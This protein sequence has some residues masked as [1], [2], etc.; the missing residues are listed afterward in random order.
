M[1]HDAV[2]VPCSGVL[3]A[4]V[5]LVVRS[6]RAGKRVLLVH[7]GAAEGAHLELG[8]HDVLDLESPSVVLVHRSGGY[9]EF[10]SALHELSSVDGELEVVLAHAGGHE[11]AAAA[12]VR[13]LDMLQQEP[14]GWSLRCVFDSEQALDGAID[15]VLRHNALEVDGVR[16]P[17]EGTAARALGLELLLEKTD[18]AEP[19]ER[20]I[21]HPAVTDLDVTLLDRLAVRH[22]ERLAR[23]DR[24]RTLEEELASSQRKAD[25][26]RAA[27]EALSAQNV[28]L[29]EADGD[30]VFL[31]RAAATEA[32]LPVVLED[33]NFRI[34]H[35]SDEPRAA[36]PSLAELLAPTRLRRVAEELQPGTPS[37]VRLG[38]PAAG[39]RLVLRLGRRRPCGYLSVLRC[40]QRWPPRLGHLLSQLEAP[41]VTAL[42]YEHGLLRI[43]QTIRSQLLRG[44]FQGTLT[45]A[46]A[47]QAGRL[48]GW[49]G[50]Q[51]RRLAFVLCGRPDE[52]GER[53]ATE[54]DALRRDAERSGIVAGVVGWGLA[55]LLPDEADAIGR[56]EDWNARSRNLAIGLSGVALSPQDAPRAL[57][58]AEWAARIACETNRHLLRFEE[59]GVDRLL[60]PAKDAGEPDL[61][62]PL[63]LLRQSSQEL[64]FDAVETVEAY[65]ESSGNVRSAARALHVHVNT[66]R[67]RLERIA[68]LSGLD[69]DDAG[70]RFEV[71]LALRLAAS[72]KVLTTLVD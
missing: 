48:M 50:H 23:Q 36:P 54:I 39:A 17:M 18:L 45:G 21:R 38:I 24:M 40:P 46:E 44:V 27:V 16:V 67:Y 51:R 58:Q 71:Q 62:R 5:D 22:R 34:R 47:L 66:L 37:L 10:R 43:E 33:E 70:S 11:V 56:L 6:C 20:L 8:L 65:L 2:V 4:V 13:L 15:A 28:N 63:Q 69:L 14:G 19:M 60:F 55:A 7:G 9:S 64:S 41:V 1:G 12:A 26:A 3:E 53:L 35:W 29:Q 57:R 68:A 25:E 72:R 49:A 52:E 32:G 59:L 31:L 30:L 42:G 61:E